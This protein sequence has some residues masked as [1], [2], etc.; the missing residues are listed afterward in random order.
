MLNGI[1]TL[2]YDPAHDRQIVQPVASVDDLSGKAA[3]KAALQREMGLQEDPNLPIVAVV[4]R[5]VSHKGFDLICETLDG[6]MDIGIQFV[7]LG[8]GDWQYGGIFQQRPV[9]VP[10]HAGGAH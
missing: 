10:R 6:M 7:L 1:D 3:C 9:P 4:S 2:R 5:L 8:K